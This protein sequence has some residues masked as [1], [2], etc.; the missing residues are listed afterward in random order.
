MKME[1]F[2]IIILKRVV[3]YGLFQKHL[4]ISMGI[5]LGNKTNECLMILGVVETFKKGEEN[6]K[7]SRKQS[8]NS[9]V[10]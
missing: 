6:P 1:V 4:K 8:I 7:I 9:E 2:V 3:E 10:E 5:C